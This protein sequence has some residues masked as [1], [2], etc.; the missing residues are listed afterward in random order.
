MEQR[1]GHQIIHTSAF[2][3]PLRPY[4]R[5]TLLLLSERPL[6]PGQH[7]EAGLLDDSRRQLVAAA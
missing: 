6:E 5:E 3:R 4:L 1:T 7:A 2:S